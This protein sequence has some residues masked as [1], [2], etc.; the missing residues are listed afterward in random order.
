MQGATHEVNEEIENLDFELVLF[1]A[2]TI[3]YDYIMKLISDLSQ[4][5]GNGTVATK[6]S[7]R[8]KSKL[9]RDELIALIQSNAKFL[10][11]ADLTAD[12]VHSLE[13]GKGLSEQ[14]VKAGYARFKAERQA[15][16]LT[17]LAAAHRLPPKGLTAFVD[18]V[19]TRMIFDGEALTVLLAPLD[20]GWKDRQ[21]KEQEPLRSLIPLLPARAGAGSTD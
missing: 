12:H 4:T 3:D 18:E 8:G 6:P 11:E 10:D 17:D 16:Q 5:P 7:G 19:L 15:E 13:E 14:Q 9:T 21:R 1:A 20:L 2:E